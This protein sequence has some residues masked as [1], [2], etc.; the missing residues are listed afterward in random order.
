MILGGILEENYICLFRWGQQNNVFVLFS[1]ENN[2]EIIFTISF[3]IFW[4]RGW[5]WKEKIFWFLKL[6][7]FSFI[8]TFRTFRTFYMKSHIQIV[9]SIRLFWHS[10]C[11]QRNSLCS[12]GGV[13]IQRSLRRELRAM[14]G[15]LDDESPLF[16]VLNSRRRER[17][18]TE[19]Q[20]SF[21][22]WF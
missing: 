8:H 11:T 19:T 7:S 15:A 20:L 2:Q 6:L 1:F 3:Y 12:E 14:K 9:M 21:K 17:R 16:V 13:D 5:I 22:R 4:P 10:L 18:S